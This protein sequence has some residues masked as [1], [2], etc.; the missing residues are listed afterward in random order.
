MTHFEYISKTF[1]CAGP[2]NILGRRIE[3]MII[4][5]RLLLLALLRDI[6]SIISYG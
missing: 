6:F 1:S 2:K 4:K 5:K 3:I